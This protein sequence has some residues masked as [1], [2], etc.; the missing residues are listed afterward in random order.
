MNEIV[1]GV[2]L[3]REIKWHSLSTEESVSELEGNYTWEDAK[4][5]PV[6]RFR[7]TWKAK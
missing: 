7:K 5:Q 4:E 1:T 2:A 3:N 6:L